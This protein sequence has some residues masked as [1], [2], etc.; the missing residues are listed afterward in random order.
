MPVF[1][2]PLPPMPAVG[3][4][5]LLVTFQVHHVMMAQQRNRRPAP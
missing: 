5:S 1:L 3:D 4:L 2:A